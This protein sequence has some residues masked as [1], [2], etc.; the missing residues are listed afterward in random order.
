MLN[1]AICDDTQGDIKKTN[2]LLSAYAGLHPEMDIHVSLFNSSDDLLF[3]SGGKEHYDL[4]LLDVIMPGSG[5]IQL[6]RHIRRRYPNAA[7]VY[8]TASEDY[9]LDAFSVFAF[10]YLIKPISRA[11]FNDMMDRFTAGLSDMSSDSISVKTGDETAT[12][13]F[14]TISYIEC[15]GHQMTFHMNNDTTLQSS[16]QRLSFNEYIK[17]LL[18]DSRFVR[19]HKSFV[20]NLDFVHKMSARD[21]TMLGGQMIPISRKNYPDIKQKYLDHVS[22]NI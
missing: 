17:P 1:I 2:D 19:T 7:I 16:S 14:N 8:T 10:Q 21:F 22:A 20:V 3:G 9:A 4:Y 12:V 5:G 13:Y 11:A 18:D 15:R 6:G